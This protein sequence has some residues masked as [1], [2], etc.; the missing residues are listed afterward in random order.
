MSSCAESHRLLAR[1]HP[2]HSGA[3]RTMSRLGFKPQCPSDASNSRYTSIP[4]SMWRLFQTNI[5]SS[6]LVVVD[7]YTHTIPIA[8]RSSDG[9]IG[10]VDLLKRMFMTLGIPDELSSLATPRNSWTIGG[11]TI[12]NRRSFFPT[13][14]VVLRLV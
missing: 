1:H 14:T 9:S 13:P 10:L 11:S 12:A 5:T 3:S 2:S 8:E 4:G 6:L 7:H